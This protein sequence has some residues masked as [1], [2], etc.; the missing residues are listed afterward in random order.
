MPLI[1]AFGGCCG[2]TK[3]EIGA[4]AA[5]RCKIFARSTSALFDGKDGGTETPPPPKSLHQLRH[6]VAE[7]IRRVAQR[8]G[9]RCACSSRSSR[10]GFCGTRGGTQRQASR[11]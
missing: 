10:L 1:A 3:P 5:S 8:T 11:M 7:Q 9:Q 2:S 4:V 6:R